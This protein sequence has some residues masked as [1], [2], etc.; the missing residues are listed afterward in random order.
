MP[1]SASVFQKPSTSTECRRAAFFAAVRVTAA[2]V[3]NTGQAPAAGL[4]AAE[5]TAFP[6]ATATGP[7]PPRQRRH[8]S[9]E[10]SAASAQAARELADSCSVAPGHVAAAAVLAALSTY[11]GAAGLLLGTAVAGAGDLTGR[12]ARLLSVQV[13]ERGGLRSLVS[14]TAAQF[15]A[16]SGVTGLTR[17]PL[18]V[19]L[20][21][22]DDLLPTPEIC[23]P[24]CD[25]LIGIGRAAGILA[26][27]FDPDRHDTAVIRAFLA[28]AEALLR[29]GA[30][31]PDTAL[32]TLTALDPRQ[33]RQI[34]DLPNR[35]ERPRRAATLPALFDLVAER[36]GERP[37]I[38]DPRSALTYRQLAGA[39][40]RLAHELRAS[41]IRPEDRVAVLISRGDLRWVVACL[42]VSYAGGAWIPLDPDGTGAR[43]TALLRHGGAAA[44]VTDGRLRAR[45]ADGPWR[46]IDVDAAA[47]RIAARPATSPAVS[48]TPRHA[49]YC[50]FTSGSTGGPRAVLVEHAS[51]VNFAESFRRLFELTPD[52]R[53]V[54]YASPGFDVSV[55]EVFA[56]L[57]AG[58]SLW[59]TGDEE[60]LS[61]E[62]LSQAL[63]RQRTTVAELP[64]VVMDMMDPAR[65]P[66]LRVASVG[67]E[68]FAGSLVTRWSAG[69]RVINGYGPAEAT[70][71]VIYKDC[72]GELRSA[73]PIGRP[74]DNQRAYV[75]SSELR[76]VPFGATGELYLGGAG[77][78][79]GYLGDPVLT[80]AH[81]VADPFSSTGER[82]LR[83]GDLAR[84]DAGGDLV[85]AGRRD[86][87]VKV[88]GQRTGL[89]EIESALTGHAAVRSAV[90]EVVAG[91]Q[92]QSVVGYVV[93]AGGD[94]LDLPALRRDLAAIVP[95]YMIP[96]RLVQVPEIPLT[97]S[98]KADLRALGRLALDGSEPGTAGAVGLTPAQH[99]VYGHCV[100]RIMPD[101]PVVPDADFFELGGTS[102]QIMRLVAAAY[103]SFG[104]EVP[105][106][107][108]LRRP[109]L[110][111]LTALVERT[112]PLAGSPY[113]GQAGPLPDG[114]AGPLPPAPRD[115]PQP[116]SP[117][118]HQLWLTNR[119]VRDRAAYNVIE[120]H[121]LRGPLDPAALCRSLR[122][123]VDRHE[124][125]RTR[126][127]E[128]DG[129]PF[130]EVDPAGGLEPE[131]IDLPGGSDEQV[132][133]LLARLLSEPFDLRADRPVRVAL[134]CLGPSDHV[135]ALV[136]HHIVSDGRSTEVL[137][138]ELSTLYAAFRAGRPSPLA[139]LAVQHVDYS[140]WQNER[141]RAGL[142]GKELAYWR[143][144][145]AGI[146]G[147][148]DLPADRPRPTVASYRGATLYAE[149]P[150]GTAARAAEVGRSA[151]ASLFMTLLAAFAAT[152][153]RYSRSRDIVVGT[154]V[155]NRPRAELDPM[156]GYLCNMLVLR[157]RC[158]GNPTFLELLGRIKGTTLAAYAHQELPFERLVQD[159]APERALGR[160]PLFQVTFQVY[161]APEEFLELPGIAVE[162][163]TVEESTC[164]FDLSVAV[165]VSRSG[166]LS[167]S[168]NYSTDLFD[169]ATARRLA[170][171]YR[172]LLACALAEPGRRLSGLDLLSAQ[173]RN[174]LLAGAFGGDTPAGGT[175]PELVERRAL[176][177]GE[178][179]AVLSEARYLTY[180]QLN[181]AA[182]RL[183]HL[184]AALGAGPGGIVAVCLD[185]DP[186]LV[187]AMLAILKAGA[188]Y[189]AID[190][191]TPASR[192]TFMLDDTGA[193]L[194]LTK[195]QFAG[196]LPEAGQRVLLD[197]PPAELGAMPQG[198]PA[199]A[200]DPRE[201]LCV[202]YTSGS[203]GRPKA[204]AI[205]HQAV[206]RLVRGMPL[207]ATS[208]RDT[209]LLM[210]PAAFDGST[211]ET[212]TPLANGARL[213]I[214]P[215]GRI[216]PHELGQVLRRHEVTVL[217]L[218]AQFTNLVVNTEPR[219]LEPL[220][221]LMTGGE[222][223][224]AAHIRRLM[225]ALPD[226]LVI[227]GY[228]PT[229]TTVFATMHPVAA[230]RLEKAASVPIGRPIGGTRIY[231][232]DP[233]LNLV[234]PGA[235]GELYIGGAGLARCYLGRPGL[236]AARFVP[237]PFG[238]AGER[239][240][241]T[242]DLVRWLPGG[243]LDFVGRCDDQVK[244]RG[245][246]IEPGEI[247]ATLM[248]R[249]EVRNAFVAVRGDGMFAELVAYVES[250]GP[251][252]AD[253]LRADLRQELPDYMVPTALVVMDALP[254]TANGKVDRRALPDPRA[255][256]KRG[257]PAGRTA[258]R[259]SLEATIVEVWADLLGRDDV[260][261]FDDFFRHGG[262]SLQATQVT[263][264]LAAR[265]GVEI[266]LA[267]IFQHPTIAELARQLGESA[268]PVRL[269]L[270]VPG[271]GN[272]PAPLS[273]GQ[274]ALW[275]LEQ[276][277]PGRP[278][279][280]VALGLRLRGA[281]DEPAMRAA[282]REI[283][284][285]HEVLRAR[286]V[287][288]EDGCPVQIS[289]P[290]DGFAVAV[291]DV[292]GLGEAQAMERVRRDA[293]EPFDLAS[294]PLVRVRLIRIG[295]DDRLLC[296]TAHHAVFDGWSVGVLLSELTSLYRAFG[297]GAAP[298]L[299][300]LEIQYRDFA[301]AQYHRRDSQELT[302][303]LAYWEQRLAGLPS[304]E[305]PADRPRP[306]RRSGRGG[307][308]RLALLSQADADRLDVIARGMGTTGSMVLVAAFAAWLAEVTAQKDI[309]FGY[310]V[311][312]RAWPEAE[313]LIGYFVNTL[314]L[315][316]DLSGDPSFAELTGRAA[317]TVLAAFAHQDVPFDRL[318]TEINPRRDPGRTPL[319]QVI[320]S[321]HDTRSRRVKLP[322][323]AVEVFDVHN[324]TAK[325][326][327]DVAVTHGVDGLTG[328]IEYSTDLFDAGTIE[329][330]A[331]SYRRVL[332]TASGNMHARLSTL[333]RK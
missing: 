71:G 36:Y 187:V 328:T 37:A 88:R 223:L 156:I 82:L 214:C 51:A 30:S 143:E 300:P 8:L 325:F 81:F 148:V 67:G 196:Q 217:W 221:L 192:A 332:E 168:F 173:E 189:L 219:D 201:L 160:N 226:L 114:Q 61:V 297:D 32:R 151:G 96:N 222:A 319:F 247:T 93:A 212:W 283:I 43:V 333:G 183:A 302:A 291:D 131:R 128:L 263:A 136:M 237:D 243:E 231:V 98:G 147:E 77:L 4:A 284:E 117:A 224:S 97:A 171:H 65:F 152:L 9:R 27:E 104:A 45:V 118:Q 272:G 169:Q 186:D 279:Y 155:S 188:A 40:R 59:I 170:D 282:L 240:Y 116:L 275:F 290:A 277:H 123:I 42:A 253:K 53:V 281:L 86:R 10:F 330:F 64:P 126:I 273:P 28:H 112:R 24:D 73:P 99:R 320:F 229:E 49:A 13:D 182:N 321:V 119:L 23:R 232:L 326:D 314:V 76:P 163:V 276:L 19:W 161:D 16:A 204:A 174:A 150:A 120:A 146:P 312:G 203:T 149:L 313:R 133:D 105:V 329:C 72:T 294:G 41:A 62:K 20:S 238:S 317:D 107:E 250:R 248:N 295:P 261:I 278:A 153:A 331:A 142:M 293:S 5:L 141:L 79:R 309:V 129:L 55:Q 124:V 327:L 267:L 287:L 256:G 2:R 164:R 190:P 289:D 233:E 103:A 78:A 262:S 316:L 135:L 176:L 56:T 7:A 211:L 132:Q 33:W 39:A 296:V 50:V 21:G 299:P 220:R 158:S 269:P 166:Q 74:A 206:V 258:P 324:G 235:V 288:G 304:L 17:L 101:A 134:V 48:L 162:K 197:D 100:A 271:S 195:R 60:R 44:V 115:A 239:L 83:T 125:L 167:V 257:R 268:G 91:E 252:D 213:A 308:C 323:V 306:P 12:S 175:I 198:N 193:R 84:F 215:P 157:T 259:T 292:S 230:E 25:L 69:H 34:V 122:S 111:T 207:L 180:A 298:S 3:G 68:P 241:Q 52:D 138:D 46:V 145:L 57:L 199:V 208:S 137:F 310:P 184:L 80:A 159:L 185:R 280:N 274:Q 110:A 121:R 225:S 94:A 54:Q 209:F 266:P 15:A 249:P 58:A 11:T 315:R 14:Q 210:A 216:G 285:R 270:P 244:M 109:T 234:P 85:F 87:Q 179:L 260:G 165:Q 218:T 236:T 307:L 102:L 127:V 106:A 63:V 66:E 311:S 265:L 35:T 172:R 75:L 181:A 251:C 90:V 108:F 177:A 154:P 205:S 255:T 286:F 140:R 38:A 26:A 70:V 178:D 227:N 47:G 318:V 303:D 246:R 242:G 322:G 202:I 194:V 130:Q 200:A 245:F 301:R 31:A 191:G 6:L 92:G 254:L 113:G 228:G 18:V 22:E 29:E 139:P 264:R 305:L 1:G 89:G 144:Q 95:G